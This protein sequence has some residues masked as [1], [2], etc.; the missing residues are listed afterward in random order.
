MR[1]Q[2]SHSHGLTTMQIFL[3]FYD[4]FQ[5]VILHK[6]PKDAGIQMIQILDEKFIALGCSF[7]FYLFILF[8]FFRIWE[9]IS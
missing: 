8:V 2:V 4:S 1:E 3:F 6:C 7:K 5:V 9:T